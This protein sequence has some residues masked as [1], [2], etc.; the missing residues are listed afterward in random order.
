[1]YQTIGRNDP[2]YLLA[3]PSICEKVAIPVE[4][5]NGQVAR[6]TVMYRKANGMFT[7]ATASDATAANYLVVIDEDVDTEADARV[8]EAAAA[9]RMG[10]V[11]RAKVLL[12]DGGPVTEAVALALRQQG[13]R[14]DP[15]DDWAEGEN[16]FDNTI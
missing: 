9:Y 11:I 14:L 8:A 2:T 4:P 7:A 16:V 15:M 10:A 12:K 1:M 3:D 13:I 5:G 6:G